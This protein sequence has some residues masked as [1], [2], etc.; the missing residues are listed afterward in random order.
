MKICWFHLMPHA[1]L[2]EDFQQKHNSVWVDVDSRLFDPKR[3][4]HMY[5]DFMDELEFAADCGFDAICVNE[6]HSNGYGMMPA[7]N[8]IASTRARACYGP[9]ATPIW[10][11]GLAGS[12]SQS[13]CCAAVRIK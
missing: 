3:A 5:N 7:P 12:S 2:P 1:D 11:G 4:H 10:T 9:S 6:H 8:L 13:Y